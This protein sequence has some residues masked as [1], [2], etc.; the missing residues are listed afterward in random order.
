MSPRTILRSLVHRI[1][2]HP[3][4][5]PTFTAHCACCG[6]TAEPSTDGEHIDVEC[7]EHAGR[8]NHR[9]FTRIVT[10]SAFVVRENESDYAPSSKKAAASSGG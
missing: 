5:A 2:A 3:D 9:R 1:V 10:G 7:I 6:W 4:I 8:S